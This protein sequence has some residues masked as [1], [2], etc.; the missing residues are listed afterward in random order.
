MGF[1]LDKQDKDSGKE[2][3]W[4]DLERVRIYTPR[5]SQDKSLVEGTFQNARN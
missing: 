4:T 5:I 2:K 1:F 3:G